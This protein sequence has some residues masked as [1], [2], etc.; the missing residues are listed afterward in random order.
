MELYRRYGPALLRKAERMLQSREEAQDLVQGLFLDLLQ[1][2]RADD[3]GAIDLPYLYRAITNR[4]LNHLRD[5][6]NQGRLIASH[7]LAAQ[8]IARTRVDD[9]I[10]DRQLL[11][12]LSGRLD[13]QSW[14]VLVYRFIDDLGEDE[15]ASLL[16][17]SRRTVAR[18]VRHIRQEV[19][20]LLADPRPMTGGRT[21]EAT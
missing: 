15:I 7:E 2:A 11:S 8:D 19:R 20:L 18:R 14:E 6:R 10:V 3:A 17:A 4:C 12:S 21:G 16:G 5:R 9:R 13:D 1:R